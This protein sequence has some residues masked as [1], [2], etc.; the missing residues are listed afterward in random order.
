M[1]N[2]LTKYV[3]GILAITFVMTSCSKNEDA[4]ATVAST[5]QDILT[6]KTVEEFNTTV[7]K[8]NTM[9]PEE[10]IAWEESNGFKSFGT[11][12][13]EVYKR[14][15]PTKFKSLQEVKDTV[16][17]LSDYLEMNQNA[18][19]QYYVDLKE[20]SNNARYL[21]NKD[22]MYIIGN[23][24]YKSLGEELISDNICNIEKLKSRNSSNLTDNIAKKGIRASI[25]AGRFANQDIWGASVTVS[26]QKYVMR[27]VLET[28]PYDY[29]TRLDR[30]TFYN[31]KWTLWTYWG[32]YL[33]H[34]T[35]N[36]IT[37]TISDPSAWQ[38][39]Q[40]IQAYSFRSTYNQNDEYYVTRTLYSRMTETAEGLSTYFLYYNIDAGNWQG[41]KVQV[42]YGSDFTA[43]KNGIYNY[44]L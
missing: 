9:K 22:K 18:D 30:Y 7:Q 32:D 37:I 21:L 11:I 33:S 40:G 8:V 43:T 10:R 17:A 31:Y 42:T 28:K 34:T 6:F 44:I 16:N 41:A 25:P 39:S 24:A 3:L 20:C 15:D 29:Q 2:K 36:I 23:I 26:G 19:G 38:I 5:K 13:D 12:C 35:S 14:I 1:K 4:L 27:V